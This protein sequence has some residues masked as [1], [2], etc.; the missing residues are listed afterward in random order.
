MKLAVDSGSSLDR[1]VMVMLGFT[2]LISS[3]VM[4]VKSDMLI[5]RSVEKMLEINGKID[6]SLDK[7]L[8]RTNRNSNAL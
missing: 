2:L 8:D 4:G 5:P 1:I 3:V 6:G 7:A